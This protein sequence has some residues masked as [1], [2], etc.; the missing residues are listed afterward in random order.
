MGV[1]Q[2]MNK[3]QREGDTSAVPFIGARMGQGS[4]PSHQQ[5]WEIEKSMRQGSAKKTSASGS[6]KGAG[7]RMKQGGK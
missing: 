1:R 2:K 6:L 3:G 4:T 7:R 5:E